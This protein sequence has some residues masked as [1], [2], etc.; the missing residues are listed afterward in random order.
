M[1][2]GHSL[3][4]EQEEFTEVKTDQTLKLKF[5]RT[6]LAYFWLQVKTSI[7]LFQSVILQL[8]YHLPRPTYTY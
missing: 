7:H 5:T 3:I 6:G 4:N 8:S 1:T 2:H